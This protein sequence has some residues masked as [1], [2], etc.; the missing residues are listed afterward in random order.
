MGVYDDVKRTLRSLVL[1]EERLD[2]ILEKAA[3]HDA[4]LT[5]H[6]RRLVRIETM[7]EMA[8]RRRLD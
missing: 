7:I 6:E 1:M 5:D 8:Q 4:A 2:R 3:A